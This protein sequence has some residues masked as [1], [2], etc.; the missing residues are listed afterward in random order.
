MV[1]ESNLGTRARLSFLRFPDCQILSGFFCSWLYACVYVLYVCMYV[2]VCM[3]VWM[4]VCMYVCMY[5]CIYVLCMSVCLYG[6]M[7][8][9]HA[10]LVKTLQGKTITLGVECS[11]TITDV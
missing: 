2:C 8:G 6:W 11:D 9:F 7:Y 5:V 10:C 3:Y 4:D 1:G